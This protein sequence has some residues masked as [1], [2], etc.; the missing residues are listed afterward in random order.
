MK[1]HEN[2][3]KTLLRCKYSQN[4]VK[5]RSTEIAGVE[6]SRKI[7]TMAKQVKKCSEVSLVVNPQK[8]CY[9]SKALE[10][11]FILRRNGLFS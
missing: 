3:K 7:N 10:I 11:N 4:L 2:V 8:V 5:E 6:F 9:R 1:I